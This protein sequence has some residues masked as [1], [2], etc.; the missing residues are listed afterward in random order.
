LTTA[1]RYEPPIE[2]DDL[3][4]PNTNARLAMIVMRGMM[5]EFPGYSFGAYAEAWTLGGTGK[6][7]KQR[8]NQAKLTAMTRA[9]A[10]LGLTL[11]LN[12]VP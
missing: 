2:Q 11:N 3:L 10:D 6:F 5:D 1:K 9:I 7:V 12:E 4:D 8:K